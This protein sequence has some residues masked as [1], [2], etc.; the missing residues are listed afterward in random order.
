MATRWWWRGPPAAC[1]GGLPP[2]SVSFT[3]SGDDTGASSC[4]A[5]GVSELGGASRRMGRVVLHACV[6]VL[7]WLFALI[8]SSLVVAGIVRGPSG[9]LFAAVFLAAAADAYRRG[10]RLAE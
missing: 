5:G 2:F 1:G 9:F 3:R 6:A 7:T 10:C 8:G 4:R